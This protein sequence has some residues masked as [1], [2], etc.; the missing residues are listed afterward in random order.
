[1]HL[2]VQKSFK[3]NKTRRRNLIASVNLFPFN[4]ISDNRYRANWMDLLEVN[5]TQ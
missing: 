2:N 5:Q 1:M 4:H 3:S